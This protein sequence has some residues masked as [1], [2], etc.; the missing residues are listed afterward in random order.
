ML[1]QQYCDA[2]KELEEAKAERDALAA[3]V[4]RLRKDAEWLCYC[5]AHDYSRLKKPSD[6]AFSTLQDTLAANSETS[7]ARLKAQWQAE[8]IAELR[9]EM[10]S[11]LPDPCR[12]LQ[13]ADAMGLRIASL[14]EKTKGGR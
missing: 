8:A 11:D 3:H 9:D 4:E 12:R 6:G 14:R 1:D 10:L 5:L 7:L 13:V 2:L